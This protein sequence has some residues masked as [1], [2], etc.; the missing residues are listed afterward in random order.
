[1]GLVEYAKAHRELARVFESF[2]AD[3]DNFHP[4]RRE[5]LG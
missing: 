5:K 2:P 4:G 3:A 1:V